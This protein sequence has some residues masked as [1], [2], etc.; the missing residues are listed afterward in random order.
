MARIL[1]CDASRPND[2][3]DGLSAATAKRTVNAVRAITLTGDTVLYRKGYC[4]DPSGSGFSS[5]QVG[6][7]SHGT[8]AGPNDDPP[9]FDGLR[10]QIP[11]TADALG[12]A[13]EGDGVWSKQFSSAYYAYRLWIGARNDGIL[14]TDRDPGTAMSRTPDIGAGAT[15]NNLT[16]IKATLTTKDIWYG[17]GAALGYRVYVLTGSDTIDPPTFYN[18]LAILQNDGVATGSLNG[19]TVTNAQ[20]VYVTGLAARG[21]STSFNVVS[22]NNDATVVENVTF[23]DCIGTHM[24]SRAFIV[25][26]SFGNYANP[27]PQ[28]K[29][30]LFLRCIGDSGSSAQEQ[31]TDSTKYGVLSGS[32]DMFAIVHN[33][34]NCRAEDCV[35]INPMHIGALVGGQDNNLFM[36]DNCGYLRHRVVAAEW[37]TYARGFTAYTCTN[38]CYFKNCVAD[39]VNVRSQFSGGV[40]VTG[41]VWKNLRQSTRKSGVSGAW[42]IESYIADFG[43]ANFGDNRYVYIQ[44]TGVLLAHNTV[45]DPYGPLLEMNFYPT[46]PGGVAANTFP[47]GVV[48]AYNNCVVDSLP[49]RAAMATITTS[50]LGGTPV[51]NQVFEN[52]DIFKGAGIAA[53]TVKWDATTY[54]LNAY[55]GFANN[56]SGDPMLGAEYTP[57]PASPCRDG[58][59]WIGGIRGANGIYP[60]TRPT[61]GAVQIGRGDQR[62]YNHA[63]T[64]IRPRQ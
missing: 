40:Q 31:E 25:H 47:S 17:A 33:A 60:G 30:V 54:A 57:A 62:T 22:S 5:M 24:Y 3:G 50:H 63:R 20:N 58:G 19:F 38:T 37:A 13:Y 4:Y 26:N 42:A 39:G 52:N 16:S 51:A 32:M 41:C 10:Y 8:Y 2:S 46:T 53:P 49:A 59:K 45:V 55:A 29:N 64:I 9:V 15:Q 27:W 61:I 36:P 56:I 28:I 23:E 48:T 11:G 21:A 14:T 43:N 6:G 7:T 1:Y 34:Y 12:W 44:P 35:S 18:G